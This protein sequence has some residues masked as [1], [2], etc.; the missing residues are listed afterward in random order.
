MWTGAVK[1]LGYGV[2]GLGRSHEG[3]AKTHRAAW[4]LYNG[5]IPEGMNVLHKCDVPCCCNP[6]HLYLGTLKD[7]SRDCVSRGRNFVPDNRGERAT[8][9][10][11][12]LEDVREIRTKL[13][14]GTDYAR[15]YG[16]S[17]SAIYQIWAGFNWKEAR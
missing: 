17:K 6:K 3:T 1:E 8:W 12:K 5:E 16:V 13:M 11:L 10:K 14:R 2:I 9:S 4:K 15:K 7:N